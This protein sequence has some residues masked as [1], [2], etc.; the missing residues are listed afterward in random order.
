MA[1]PLPLDPKS[2]KFLVV[3]CTATPASR[4]LSASDIDRMHRLERGWLAIGYHFVVRRDGTVERG[5]PETARGAHV[6]NW[7]HCSIGVCLVGG[8]D[9]KLKPEANFTPA[10]FESLSKLLHELEQRYPT[11]VIQGH[12]DFPGVAK[13]CPSFNVK[14][15]L[16]TNKVIP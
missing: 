7:N 8:V 15:W 3:H 5:R 6:E 1:G 13:A 11:A 4:D 10:Q 2:V 12:R 14:H 16:A 9:A